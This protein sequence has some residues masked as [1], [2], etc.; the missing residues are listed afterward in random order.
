[1]P[2]AALFRLNLRHHP[3]HQAAEQQPMDRGF[4]APLCLTAT[5]GLALLLCLH[6]VAVMAFVLMLPF[7]RFAHGVFRREALLKFAI[8]KRQPSGLR[9]GDD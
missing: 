3:L 8:E 7:G 6:L 1:M 5:S 2:Q 4:I 9:L